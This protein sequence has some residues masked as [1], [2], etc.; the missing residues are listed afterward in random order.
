M[1]VEPAPRYRDYVV[2]EADD[3]PH[4]IF[5]HSNCTG[6]SLR[7]M[8]HTRDFKPFI[9]LNKLSVASRTDNLRCHADSLL[10]PK[11]AVS[12]ALD[13]TSPGLTGTFFDQRF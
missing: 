6:Q 12:H 3:T 10:G 5:S 1:I 13:L 8:R 4:R 2:T 7:E 9:Y 11:S